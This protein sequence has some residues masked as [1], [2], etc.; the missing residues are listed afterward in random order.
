MLLSHAPK[1]YN[2]RQILWNSVESAK[3]QHNEQTSRMVVVPLS[4]EL[5]KGR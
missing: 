3:K 5:S 2:D 1:E 4:N